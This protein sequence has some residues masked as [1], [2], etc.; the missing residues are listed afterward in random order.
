[1]LFYNRMIGTARRVTSVVKMCWQSGEWR[2]FE[3]TGVKM[4]WEGGEWRCFERAESED[5]LTERKHAVIKG[6]MQDKGGSERP[7][8]IDNAEKPAIMAWYQKL[9]VHEIEEWGRHDNVAWTIITRITNWTDQVTT[10]SRV[11]Y[12]LQHVE[13]FVCVYYK[14]LDSC[15][16]T[17]PNI[18]VS[19]L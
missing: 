4:F 12:L 17:A 16:L 14:W 2:C 13:K 7:R 1:M 18:V 6:K 9:S 19:E 15:P 3:R 5:V 10:H 8:R 11:K